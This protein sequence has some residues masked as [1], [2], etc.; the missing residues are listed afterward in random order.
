MKRACMVTLELKNI[1][2][3][4]DLGLNL[5]KT[6]DQVLEQFLKTRELTEWELNLEYNKA[7]SQKAY[8]EWLKNYKRVIIYE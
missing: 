7:I 1:E 8:E 5:S 4:K 3:I 2:R 6:I